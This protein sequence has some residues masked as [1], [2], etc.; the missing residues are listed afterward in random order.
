MCINRNIVKSYRNI[1][2][3]LTRLRR[4]SAM[5]RNISRQLAIG[6]KFNFFKTLFKLFLTTHT[7]FLAIIPNLILIVSIIIELE[8]EFKL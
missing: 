5:L 2:R 8:R 3:A 4:V 1:G 7:Q 6:I